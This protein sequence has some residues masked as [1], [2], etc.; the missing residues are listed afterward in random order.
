MRI[1]IVSLEH[2]CREGGVK[3][4]EVKTALVKPTDTV[5]LNNGGLHRP[6]ADVGEA[7]VGMINTPKH[8]CQ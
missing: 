2:S 1:T 8:G 4:K 7:I 6:H 5:D 3:N